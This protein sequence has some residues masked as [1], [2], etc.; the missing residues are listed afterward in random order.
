[1]LKSAA[2]KVM[3]VGRA[4]VL[5]VGLAVILAAL[6]IGAEVASAATVQQLAAAWGGNDR[7]QLGNGTSGSGTDSNVPVKVINLSAVTGIAA[8]GY[9][10]LAK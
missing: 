4:R 10:S 1:M 7:G 8:G 5:V 2:S 9:H 3:L 6:A